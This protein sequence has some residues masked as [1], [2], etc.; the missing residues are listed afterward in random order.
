[1]VWIVYSLYVSA[2]SDPL[3]SVFLLSGLKAKK[4]MRPRATISL[5]LTVREAGIVG[6][7]AENG[8]N[9]LTFLGK[10]VARHFEL[11]MPTQKDVSD[12]DEASFVKLGKRSGSNLDIVQEEGTVPPTAPMEGEHKEKA[13][14]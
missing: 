7:D 14:K 9:L 1:M 11:D 6:D 3:L 4:T 5:D 2:H 10:E 12:D 8:Y 13:G